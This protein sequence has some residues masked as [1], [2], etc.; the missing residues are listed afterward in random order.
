MTRL[1]GY[2]LAS[3][4]LTMA[5]TW[6]LAAPGTIAIDVA[7]YRM[8]PRIGV[9]VIALFTLIFASI[10]LWTLI[11]RLLATPS[12]LQKRAQRNRQSH[13]IDALS[14]SF[15]ALQAGDANKARQLAREAQNKL[16][17]NAAAQL[18]EARAELALGKWGEARNQYKKLIDNPAT[19]LAALSG[20]YEQAVG[21]GRQDAALTFAHKAHSLAPELTWASQAIFHDLTQNSDWAAALKMVHEEPSR[22]RSTKQ[23]KK[24]RLAIL[25]TAIAATNETSNSAEALDNV[26]VALKLEPDFVPAALIAARIH[27]N[28][29]ELRKSTSLLRRVWRANQHPHIATLYANAQPG[30]SPVERLKRINEL[31]STPPPDQ[32][33]AIVIANLAIQAKEWSTAR[34]ALTNFVTDSPSQSTCVAMAQIEEGQ[35]DDHGR[36]RQWLAKAVSAP[37]D[38]VWIADG[39]TAN[40][41]SPVSPV[42]GELDAYEFKVPSSSIS[43][44]E[45]PGPQFE[46]QP[47]SINDLKTSEIVEVTPDTQPE[48]DEKSST[49][50]K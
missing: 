21:Q 18:L 15:I 43:L 35:N 49:D 26:R 45:T 10:F 41:W 32:E 6:L 47:S 39:V 20:L 30:I 16:P 31:I 48:L 34:T 8:Q 19:S 38:P 24:R 9:S 12:Y 5:I 27:S 28:R 17:Q 40:E 22:T 7:G 46:L 14:N 36:A 29:G 25:H 42:T 50:Q 37:R 44:V 2:V 11:S 1:I 4:A 23:N 13:G 3:L 33:S